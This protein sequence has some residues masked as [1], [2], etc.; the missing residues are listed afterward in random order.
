M[1]RLKLPIPTTIITGSL[2]VGKTTALCNLVARK[3]ADEV[4]CCLPPTG[5]FLLT[6]VAAL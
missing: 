5:T 1:R 3:P 4:C 6:V 2:G